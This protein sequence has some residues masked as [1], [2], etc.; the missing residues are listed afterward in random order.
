MRLGIPGRIRLSWEITD[1]YPHFHTPRGYGVTF[2]N[3]GPA[4]HL[5]FPYKMLQAK[6]SRQDGVI[7]HELGHVLDLCIRSSDLDAW[8]LSQ[9]I[10]LPPPKHAEIRADA[11]VHAVWGKALKYDK[12]LVQTTGRGTA[13]RPRHLGL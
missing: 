10:E 6:K 1:D 11:I 2:H 13:P 5:A 3:G 12:D 8:A 4:C 9:G 7:Q